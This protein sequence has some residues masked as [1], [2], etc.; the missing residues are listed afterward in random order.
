M[1]HWFSLHEIPN[2]FTLVIEVIIGIAIALII[3]GLQSKTDTKISEVISEVHSYTY[4][5]SL[6]DP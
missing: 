4:P 3:F 6:S 1:L 2:S 5:E